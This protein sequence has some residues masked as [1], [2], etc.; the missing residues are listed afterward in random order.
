M[1]LQTARQQ[2]PPDNRKRGRWMEKEKNQ[3]QGEEMFL[4]IRWATDKRRSKGW[5]MYRSTALEDQSP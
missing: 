5:A 4:G 1:N 2:K 3:V